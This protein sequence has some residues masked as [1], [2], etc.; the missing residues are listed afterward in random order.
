[1]AGKDIEPWN[2][3]TDQWPPFIDRSRVFDSGAWADLM[4]KELQV[5]RQG[6]STPDDWSYLTILT[7]GFGAMQEWRTALLFLSRLNRRPR[8]KGRSQDIWLGVP[9]QE[10]IDACFREVLKDKY[11]AL[12]HRMLASLAGALR[13]DVVLTTNFDDLLERAFE[14]ARNPL[15]VFEVQL[16]GKL[17]DWSTVSNVRALVKLHGGRSSLRADYTLDDAPTEE[18]KHRF[19][20]YL[21]SAKGRTQFAENQRENLDPKNHLLMIGFSATDRRICNLIDYAWEKLDKSRFRVYWICFSKDDTRRINALIHASLHSCKPSSEVTILRHK[22]A[23]LFFLELYQRLRR[24]LPPL[25]SIFPSIARLTLPPL[26][27]AWISEEILRENR[28]ASFASFSTAIEAKLLQFDKDEVGQYK[29]ILAHSP[30]AVS[31][32][33][34]AC[35]RTFR[36]IESKGNKVCL[37]I[38]MNDIS[39]ADNLFEVLLEAIYYKLGFEDWIPSTVSYQA[40]EST[41]LGDRRAREIDRLVRSVNKRWIVFLNGYET[42][43]ANTSDTQLADGNGWLSRFFRANPSEHSQFADHSDCAQDLMRLLR[44]LCGPGSRMSVVLMCRDRNLF[45][46]SDDEEKLTPIPV[47]LHGTTKARPFF[48]ETEI[49][50]RAI[51]WAGKDSQKQRFLHALILIQ[52]PRHLATLWS[53]ALTPADVKPQDRDLRLAWIDELEDRGL[54]RRKPGGLIWIHSSCRQML[55][56]LLSRRV[57]GTK[58]GKHELPLRLLKGWNPS[59]HEAVIHVELAEWYERVLDAS[60]APAAV[61]ESAFHFCKAAVA[62]VTVK[63][64]GYERARSNIEAATSLLRTN[65]YLIQTHGYSR[66]SCRRLELIASIGTE[67]LGAPGMQHSGASLQDVR[68]AVSLL[69]Q[70]CAEVMRAVAREV[71]EDA[72]AFYRH[73][74]V[75]RLVIGETWDEVQEDA[76]S[77]G[78][79]QRLAH[80]FPGGAALEGK[81]IA[82]DADLIRWQRWSG[83]LA[84]AS[85][86]YD[87]A[88][89]RFQK[90]IGPFDQQSGEHWKRHRVEFTSRRQRI[91]FLRTIE[92]GAELLL[93]QS[94]AAIRGSGMPEPSNLAKA[95]AMLDQV[96]A[97]V[98][99]GIQLAKKVRDSDLSSDAHQVMTANWCETRL[100][101]HRSIA[102]A[103][104]RA[105]WNESAC[106]LDP[107]GILGDAEAKL[108]V[109]DAKKAR[110]EL[111]MIDLHRA[112]VRIYEAEMINLSVTGAFVSIGSIQVE[113]GR[114]L[115]STASMLGVDF[116]RAY[117]DLGEL[118]KASALV[119]DSIRFLNRAEPVLRDRRRNVWWTTWYFERKLRAIGFSV[120]VSAFD[121]GTP[122]PFLGLEA[123]MRATETEADRLLNDAIR[124]IRVDVYRLATVI[125]AYFAIIKALDLRL[126]IE[127]RSQT[128]HLTRI[129]HRRHQMLSNLREA[130]QAFTEVQ[131]RRQNVPRHYAVEG[132]VDGDV[133]VYLQRFSDRIR[134]FLELAETING[135]HRFDR[136]HLI[137]ILS[138]HLSVESIVAKYGDAW[139]HA[140]MLVNS[141][142]L[143]PEHRQLLSW[144]TSLTSEQLDR[145]LSM[146]VDLDLE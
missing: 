64:Y 70:Q 34:S 136:N 7:E 19:L 32:I 119:A 57:T 52:R 137:T 79:A 46:P 49:C 118:T 59:K 145:I 83:M 65:S 21:L 58:P 67:I 42:P 105:Y 33:T 26:E 13:Q 60:E 96:E 77:S 66:G 41:F 37:W 76:K 100:L 73:R 12:G 84:L 63:E 27:P 103:R 143:T 62:F 17:P 4:F 15:E 133:Q 43:G 113:V 36:E 35:A 106:V 110:S 87:A 11:P 134:S 25:G 86:S 53:P 38:D 125:D 24:T 138:E 3:R 8:N 1:M 101:M 45:V 108:R 92:Q 128:S 22:N 39:S 2:P 120:M 20:H 18:D 91:E 124:M 80:V 141:N 90:I 10:V 81:R 29:V 144:K 129:P 23:G 126:K 71:G 142:K 132:A 31:G 117:F 47:D 74:Q 40:A 116:W 89:V 72:K 123:A 135:L 102:E 9:Q 5:L 56:Q 30:P 14:A 16:E 111:A 48:L 94:N 114:H 115:R 140:E 78:L 6:A 109:F 139:T 85:R 97:L 130:F 95:Q 127:R 51:T 54:V 99:R 75:A 107:M 68:D 44:A 98:R 61:F 88:A 82:G 121:P 93:L 69:W 112:E 131:I 55:R 50:E 122:V 28:K 146:P 104:R